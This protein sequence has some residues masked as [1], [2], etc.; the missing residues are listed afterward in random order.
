MSIGK[1]IFQ[2]YKT[3]IVYNCSNKIGLATEADH[4]SMHSYAYDTDYRSKTYLPASG[5]DNGN[6]VSM[7]IKTKNKTFDGYENI[8]GRLQM[9]IQES[10]NCIYFKEKNRLCLRS[11]I[12]K[13]TLKYYPT[14][15]YNGATYLRPENYVE[16]KI[17]YGNITVNE[18]ELFLPYPSHPTFLENYASENEGGIKKSYGFLKNGLGEGNGDTLY[19]I[20]TKQSDG[21]Y[22]VKLKKDQNS[23]GSYGS[24]KCS[25]DG[26]EWEKIN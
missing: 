23:L 7:T 3:E 22:I 25:A 14:F 19:I 16:W 6:G 13:G 15:K 10:N 4:I 12:E 1:K 8:L 26:T 17:D 20:S 21:S 2:Y 24:F 18:T 9:K 11:W 5:E